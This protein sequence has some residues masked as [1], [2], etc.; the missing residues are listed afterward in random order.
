MNAEVCKCIISCE[1]CRRFKKPQE[2]AKL[3]PGLANCPFGLVHID[4]LTIGG[5]A[6]KNVLVVTDHFTK[7]AKAYVTAS[8]SAS[9]VAKTL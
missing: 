2:R 6:D 7:F 9:V 8:Q 1:S 5:G 3:K 4:F